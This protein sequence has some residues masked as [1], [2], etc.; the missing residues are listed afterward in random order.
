MIKQGDS[1]SEVTICFGTKFK[2]L[3]DLMQLFKV[4]TVWRLSLRH[5]HKV[6]VEYHLMCVTQIAK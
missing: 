2:I 4:I 1:D 5:C 3:V 6:F